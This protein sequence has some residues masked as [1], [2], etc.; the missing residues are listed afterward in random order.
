M[1]EHGKDDRVKKDIDCQ[2]FEDQID[3]FSRGVLSEEGLQQLRLHADMCPE[4]AMQLR[5]QEHLAIPSLEE[6][7]AAVPDEVLAAVWPGIQGEMSKRRAGSAGRARS[8]SGFGWL[9]LDWLQPVWLRPTVAAAT[10]V[11]AIATGFL[12]SELRQ[13]KAREEAL[14]QRI[15]QLDVRSEAVQR[16]ASLAGRS[17][18]IRALSREGSVSIAALQERLRDLPGNTVV[19][20][21]S[22]LAAVLANTATLTPPIWRAALAEYEGSEGIRVR[23]LL[24]ILESSKARSDRSV[25]TSRVIQLLD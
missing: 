21:A 20:D 3:A 17:P 14:V 25:P 6:L 7:E 2:V 10:V 9:S 13:S 18:L 12:F 23:D 15:S 1:G 22:E 5:V 16:T 8:R 24:A 4:C 19:L 11:W